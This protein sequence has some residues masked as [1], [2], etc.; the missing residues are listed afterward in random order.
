M[1][2]KN[3]LQENNLVKCQLEEFLMQVHKDFKK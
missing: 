3:H 1:N 2:I